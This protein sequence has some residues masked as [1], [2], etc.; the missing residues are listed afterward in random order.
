M[1]EELNAAAIAAYIIIL[2]VLL[3]SAVL[4]IHRIQR[5]RNE[6]IPDAEARPWNIPWVDFLLF[7]CAEI[8]I[9]SSVQLIGFHLLTDT[10]EAADEQLTPGLAIAA[11]LLL[12]IPMLG[13]FY[14]ARRFF[15]NLYASQL[16]TQAYSLAAALREAASLFIMFL[17]VIWIANYLWSR[18]LGTLQSLGVINEVPVQDLV[19]IFQDGG[20]PIT[21]TILVLFA[22]LLAPFVE[23]IIFR[24]CIYRFL[25]SK[26]TFIAAQVLSG[27]VFSIMHFNLMTFIPLV[28]I[29][30][31][32]ARIYEKTGN[33]LVPMC[34][35]AFFNGFSL[36][37]LYILSHANLPQ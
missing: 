36:L 23:E 31:I 17:P 16:N 12:Q 7:I 1:L 33:L 18:L 3:T 11:V 9:V 32:L 26:T 19:K 34:F 35:H 29:G 20:E 22:V 2:G 13:V 24:G 37:M 15:P 4:W 8:V 25:K 27:I 6:I 14:L 5:P 10:I 21:I 28:V 30:I